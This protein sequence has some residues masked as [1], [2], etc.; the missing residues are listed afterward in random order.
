MFGN[1]TI[2]TSGSIKTMSKSNMT[3]SGSNVLIQI[4]TSSVIIQIDTSSVIIQINSVIIQ[5]DT[6]NVVILDTKVSTDFEFSCLL[7]KPFLFILQP[8][9][10]Q[11]RLFL[12]EQRVH[13]HSLL[14]D[15]KL[16]AS[17]LRDKL[18]SLRTLLRILLDQ[19]EV[20]RVHKVTV[21]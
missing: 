6:N 10:A 19:N 12:N 5:I 20:V 4:D 11:L 15:D 18:R 8:I 9:L 21:H 14:R 16:R 2:A 13:A 3:T 17:W 1:I 7:S